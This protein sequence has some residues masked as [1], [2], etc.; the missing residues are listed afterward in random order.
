MEQQKV[1]KSVLRL[2]KI[3][4][5]ALELFLKKGYEETNLRDI[6]AISGGSFSDIYKKFTNKQGLF[7][8]LISDIIQETHQKDLQNLNKKLDLREFLYAFTKNFIDILGNERD[9]ALFKLILSQL[10]NSQNKALVEFFEKNQEISPEQVLITYFKGCKGALGKD[11]QRYAKL[12]LHIL[13]G[14]TVE[15]VVLMRPL[16]S[17][18]ERKEYTEF[19]VEFFLK[20]VS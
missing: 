17:E 2:E 11:S 18:K 16:M 14:Y 7:F 19:V 4:S 6:I 10:H 3:K 1:K 9:L 13:R 15:K 12:F 5:T 20:A 8:S